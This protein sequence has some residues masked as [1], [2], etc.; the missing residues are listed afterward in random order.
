VP[1]FC[2]VARLTRRLGLVLAVVFAFI[3]M[4]TGSACAFSVSETE[5][6]DDCAD[7]PADECNDEHALECSEDHGVPCTPACA[8]CPGCSGPSSA[9]LRGADHSPQ[10][11]TRPVVIG[12][13]LTE[14]VPTAH[15]ERIDRP[16]CA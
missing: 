3:A 13:V 8:D 14:L 5:C 1:E 6:A 9:V 7:A 12:D 15:G 10:P 2:E 11:R 4:Q 16:P